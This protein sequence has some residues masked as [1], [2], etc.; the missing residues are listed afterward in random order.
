MSSDNNVSPVSDYSNISSVVR[1]GLCH[2]C[3]VCGG[4]CPC[5]AISFD[6]DA[7][8]VVSG[9]C[10]KCGLCLKV[11]S[12]L[13]YADTAQTAFGAYGHCCLGSS[14][15]EAIRGRSASGGVVTEIL[16]YLIKTG[17]VKKV[18]VTSA[19]PDDPAVP[20]SLLTGSDE[21]IISA[22]QSKYSLFPWGRIIREVMTRDE[23]FAAVGLACHIQSLRKAISVIPALR[24]N[25]VLLIGLF[26]ESNIM[27]AGIKHLLKIKGIHS[28]QLD[29]IEYR[30]GN[31]PGVMM[32]RLKN[33]SKIVLSNRNGQT[34]AINYLKWTYG[35]PR[36]RLCYDMMCGSAD[37]SVG[38]PWMRSD[39]GRYAYEGSS[40]YSAVVVRSGRGKEII[41]QMIRET[42]ISC[43]EKMPEQLIGVQIK[44]AE[45]KRVYTA[46]QI[47]R[48]RSVGR[49]YPKSSLPE[50]GTAVKP[51]LVDRLY[52]AVF[53]LCHARIL[54]GVF[55]RLM[56]SPVGDVIT[57][58]N[59]LRKMLK[60]RCAAKNQKQT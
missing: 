28:G 53:T 26:C 34:G 5:S 16:R 32:A 29:K 50:P 31:W 45:L 37:I 15:D 9:A 18:V 39:S 8:P 52:N 35:Q 14:M 23:P 38:D 21:A 48:M 51:L 36:C 7:L 55:L 1:D 58:L 40:G 49:P 54:R 6:E 33:G 4:V 3:G 57:A 47:A 60:W 59:S 42:V 25:A 24:K 44:Q 46:G 20:V 41:D 27:P 12:G 2:R 22:C 43:E 13:E 56:L 30:H 19:S 10:N 17:R 11:C